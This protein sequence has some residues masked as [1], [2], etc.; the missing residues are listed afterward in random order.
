[1]LK[2]V[3][4][5]QLHAAEF[6]YQIISKLDTIDMKLTR[7]IQESVLRKLL[8][9]IST[10]DL[11]LQ[12]K[13][14]HLLHATMAITAS[15]ALGQKTSF[16]ERPSQRKASIDSS[17]GDSMA[18]Y[19]A[20]T[21]P[22]ASIPVGSVQASEA[23]DLATSSSSLFVKCVI[24]AFTLSTNRPILQHWMDFVL[25]S[26]PHMRG[27]FRQMVIPIL[28]AMC[29]QIVLCNTTV[30]ILMHGEPSS[31]LRATEDYV[32]HQ[33][34][35]KSPYLQEQGALVGG[36][37]QDILVFLNGLEKTL[38]FCMTERHLN[39]DWYPD[40]ASEPL[41]PVPRLADNSTL[42]IL[43]QLVHSD[44]SPIKS[45][46]IALY[47]L[48]IILHIL[49]DVW[50]VFRQPEWNEETADTLG[51]AKK[52]AVLQSFAYAADHVKARLE[53]IFEHLYKY[54]SIDFT[55]GFTEIFF[56]EN[57]IALE[58][59]VSYRIPS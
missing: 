3:R 18:Q 53:H 50:R 55:E 47:H 22:R 58:Y 23:I 14:L 27:G 54:C 24:D 57:P 2:P 35:S 30:R 16:I 11:E 51:H 32:T 40:K 15:A 49:L 38:M 1:M 41:L 5:I 10:S 46:D 34:G 28:I 33:D 31:Q 39:D 21:V 25:A 52:D 45:R 19:A 9:C 37:E 43:A 12:Q 7:L 44:T 8:F 29:E 56:M 48:P 6:L 17:T 4:S 59:E 42:K 13:L 26:L 20:D 36:P